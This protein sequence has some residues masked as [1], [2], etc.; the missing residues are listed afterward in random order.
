MSNWS[1]T[2]AD[3]RVMPTFGRKA[4]PEAEIARVRSA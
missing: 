2:Y 4:A 1:Y 3:L